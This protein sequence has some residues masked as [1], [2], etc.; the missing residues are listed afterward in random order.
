MRA[1][2]LLHI[3]AILNGLSKESPSLM[4]L[5]AHTVQRLCVGRNRKPADSPYHYPK[6]RCTR[7]GNLYRFISRTRCTCQNLK[8]VLKTFIN[9]LFLGA[10]CSPPVFTQFQDSMLCTRLVGR[11]D[12]QDVN[13]TVGLS[14]TYEWLGSDH[15][16]VETLLVYFMVIQNN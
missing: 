9:D 2:L 6:I 12:R 16:D 7:L 3:E 11:I 4:P 10:V 15:L 5:M 8:R 1:K 14:C 13:A